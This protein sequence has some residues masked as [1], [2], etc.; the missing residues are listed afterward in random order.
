M[1]LTSKDMLVVN[2]VRLMAGLEHIRFLRENV[3]NHTPA[4]A[5]A[6]GL[7][8]RLASASNSALDGRP[9]QRT[10]WTL[11]PSQ[12]Q[13]MNSRFSCM[14]GTALTA[15]DDSLKLFIDMQTWP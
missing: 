2:H 15:I 8:A 10:V 4:I 5:E 7:S 11:S 9:S 6:T 1:R 12:G 13:S 14:D 3:P